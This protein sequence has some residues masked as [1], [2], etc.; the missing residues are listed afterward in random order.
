M[1]FQYTEI[2]HNPLHMYKTLDIYTKDYCPYCTKAKALLN[3]LQIPFNDHDI[4]ETP[5]VIEELSKKSGF[6][7]VPQIFLGDT[8]LGG[9]SDIEKLHQEGKLTEM[10]KE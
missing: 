5:E 7:T 9:Y 10:C 3:E 2:Q 4:S 1:P 8:A 6:R